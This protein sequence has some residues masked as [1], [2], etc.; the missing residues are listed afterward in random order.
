M[1]RTYGYLYVAPRPRRTVCPH[2]GG[3]MSP[4]SS[5]PSDRKNVCHDR[6][7]TEEQMRKADTAGDR[8]SAYGAACERG[9]CL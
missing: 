3:K 9:H 7:C 6:A 8:L 4:A 1:P 5:D 2:C